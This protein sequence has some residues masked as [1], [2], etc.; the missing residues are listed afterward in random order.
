MNINPLKKLWTHLLIVFDGNYNYTIEGFEKTQKKFELPGNL[1][2]AGSVDQ[3]QGDH[4]QPFCKPEPFD[5]G[6]RAMYST[7]VPSK[8]FQR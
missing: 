6:N 1:T 5:Q 8:S 4:L 7:R 2:R 3:A